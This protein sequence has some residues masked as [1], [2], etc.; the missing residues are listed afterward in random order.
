MVATGNLY[1][2]EDRQ[3]EEVIRRG[4]FIVVAAPMLVLAIMA[5]GITAQT[6]PTLA[7][8]P[9]A[10]PKPPGVVFLE[11]AGMGMTEFA[12]LTFFSFMGLVT[13]A[14]AAMKGK[15]FGVW[16]IVGCI[17]W[18]AALPALVLSKPQQTTSTSDKARRYE[19]KRQ[20]ANRRIASNVRQAVLDRDDYLCRYCGRRSQTMEV[21]H[22][23]PVSQG[24]TS[25]LDN[26]VTACRKCNRRKAGR[27][28]QEA[29]MK[30]LPVRTRIRRR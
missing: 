21:D 27:T 26:L 15:R 24:G 8:T 29:G 20:Q 2:Y 9:T 11:R 1:C 6:T 22:I 3:G 13:G 19:P 18:F 7:P 5:C 30:V 14:V 4:P 10:T 12:V 25:T 17:G 23:I 16:F 28:P